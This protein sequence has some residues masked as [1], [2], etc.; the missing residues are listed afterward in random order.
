MSIIKTT[1]RSL[2]G[3][4]NSMIFIA[5]II[6]SVSLSVAVVSGKFL[7][8]RH[9]YQVKI[10]REKRTARDTLK[11]NVKTLSTLKT[12]LVSLDQT[13][14]NSQVVLEALPSQ[15]DYPA[16]GSSLELIAEKSAQDKSKFKFSGTDL[17]DAPEKQS[18]SP[19]PFAM[20][21][22]TVVAGPTDKT[23][24]FL[25]DLERSIRPFRVNTMELKGDDDGVSMTLTAESYYQ[26]T[27]NLEITTKEV[28]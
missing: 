10:M 1:K 7:L 15:Y 12:N 13:T 8:D 17:G 26:P 18:S 24:Q 22:D 20:P 6:G 11:E 21:F 23:L 14:Y 19:V 16:L 28:K 2:I 3:K 27:K 5:A 9:N 4:A 25:L